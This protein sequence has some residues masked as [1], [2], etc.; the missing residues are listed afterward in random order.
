M[1][2]GRGIAIVPAAVATQQPR[3]HIVY[4]PVIDADPAVVSLASG[5]PQ[6]FVFVIAMIAGMTAVRWMRARP[7]ALPK[8]LGQS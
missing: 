6:V 3:P 8:A 5:R 7:A 1:A 4:V 2:A